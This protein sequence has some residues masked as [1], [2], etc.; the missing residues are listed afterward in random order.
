MKIHNYLLR[1]LCLSFTGLFLSISANGQ[2]H[3]ALDAI[4]VD[5]LKNHV[6][7]LASDF[8]GGRVSYQPG[9]NIA[10]E[11]CVSQLKSAGLKPIMKGK[12]GELTYFQEV[13]LLKQTLSNEC[14]VSLIGSKKTIE[15]EPDK[16]FKIVDN[17][18]DFT[19][20]EIEIVFAGYGISEPDHKWDDFKDLDIEGK[21]VIM[22]MDAPQKKGKNV[23]PEGIHKSYQSIPGAQKKIMSIL[24]K[25]PSAVLFVAN[26]DLLKIMPWEALPPFK[27]GDQFSYNSGENKEKDFQIPLIYVIHPN[28]VDK[29]FENQKYSPKLIKEKGLKGYKTFTFTDKKL[30]SNFV[31]EKKEPIICRNVVA[32][33]EGTDDVLKNEYVSLVAHLDHVLPVN[34]EICNGADDNASGSAGVLE[35]AESMVMNPPKRSTIFVL[36]TAEELG[37]IG[38]Q[39]FVANPPVPM[40]N[41][42]FNL[43]LDMIGRSAKENIESRAH[44][45]TLHDKY[46]KE[47][48]N[49]LKV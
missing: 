47:I 44:E 30:K 41:I 49:I 25:K 45:V 11:Y 24:S 15:L 39:H 13:P 14:S 40:E 8:L 16:D 20:S 9:F 37:L 18:K 31:I 42:I 6:Y 5:E 35:V 19:K 32:V 36:F 23:L 29:L 17:V 38:S 46:F 28:S 22:I 12:D 1:I 33:L 10:A 2:N 43:N 4:S 3:K 26:N 21:A 27:G 48:K 7:F 34:G